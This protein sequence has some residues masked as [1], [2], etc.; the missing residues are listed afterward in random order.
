ME[1]LVR[2]K[3]HANA[4]VLHAIF[5]L[6]AARQDDELRTL[7]HHILIANRFWLLLMLGREF[8]REKETVVPEK[9]EPLIEQYRETE[10]LEME[11]LSRFNEAELNRQLVTPRLPGRTFTVGEAMMQTIMHSHGHRA[12]AAIRLRSLGGTPP[13]TDFI[14][15]AMDRPRPHW[16]TLAVT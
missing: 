13:P 12:Q 10:A 15:W 6:P 2:H 14:L 11:W 8:N 5:D 1:E 4:A 3:W 7:L 16:P 9:L